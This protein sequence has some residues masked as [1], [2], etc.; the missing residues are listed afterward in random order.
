MTTVVDTMWKMQILYS[1]VAMHVSIC[2]Y[3]CIV[4]THQWDHSYVA[5]HVLC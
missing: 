5:M 4:L 1:Y 2:G 3:A